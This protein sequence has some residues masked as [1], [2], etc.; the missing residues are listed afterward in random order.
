MKVVLREDVVSSVQ[1]CEYLYSCGIQS[2]FIEGGAKVLNH[3]ISTGLWDEARIFTG[4]ASFREGVKAPL[5]KGVPFS[6]IEFSSSSLEIYLK[7][8]S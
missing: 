5:I 2:L 3:F 7:D 1:I 8:G 4:K 6:K